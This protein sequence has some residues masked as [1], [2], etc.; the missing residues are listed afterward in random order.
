MIAC[1]SLI[2]SACSTT[3]QSELSKSNAIK[4]TWSDHKT[5][6]ALQNNF[7]AQ[8]KVAIR[9]DGKRNSA[10]LQW[11]QQGDHYRIFI[12][13]P[14]GSGAVT[15]TGSTQGVEMDISGEGRFYASSPEQ[16]MEQR[17]GWSLPISNLNYW[18]KG[19]PSPNSG[20]SHALDNQERLSQLQQNQWVIDYQSYH[21]LADTDWPRKMQLYYG[22]NIQVTLL[23]KQ[24]D[25]EKP[26][27]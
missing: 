11:Q 21:H 1:A 6:V 19:I 4:S 9:Q 18:A 10:T 3:P 13:G 14:L 22:D 20:F 16:L 8:G 27:H 23:I 15:I 25:F 7:H 24:W 2:L 12:T 17:L 5:Y 26:S